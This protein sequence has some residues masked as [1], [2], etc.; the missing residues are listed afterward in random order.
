[1]ENLNEVC[2][3][4]LHLIGEEPVE[5]WE[6]GTTGTHGVLRAHVRAVIREVE[7]MARWT[8]LITATTLTR[9]GTW[10]TAMGAPFDLP[11]DWLRLVRVGNAER[12][13]VYEE[14]GGKLWVR[15]RE[16]PATL[17]AVYVR[18]SEAPREWSAELTTCVV[19]LLAARI[20]G[21]IGHDLTGASGM[22]QRF[23]QEYFPT[24]AGKGEEASMVVAS[25]AQLT[26]GALCDGAL[27]LLG[28]APV[29]D[30]R[31]DAST[32]AAALRACLPTVMREVQSLTRWPELVRR[33]RLQWTGGSDAELGLCFYRPKGCLRVLSA[34]TH[35]TEEGGF[36][37]VLG[38]VPDDTA[39]CRFVK[40][41]ENPAEWSSELY[42]LT[43]QL[44][45]ARAASSGVGDPARGA[46][47]EQEFWSVHRPRAVTQVLNRARKEN[48]NRGGFNG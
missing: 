7:R 11:A 8:E 2:N 27:R 39:W 17:D 46:T 36:L 23:W 24:A 10:T 3:A 28:A 35:W 32:S 44:L 45:A 21:G 30:W 9:T 14:M 19:K 16:A 31:G 34:G 38:A 5:D 1:M 22:E 20:L 15:G 18:Y 37:F 33:E 42:G 25:N 12:E 6:A 13:Y 48:A 43:M 29:S 4:A 40:Y 41:S 47:L 26:L